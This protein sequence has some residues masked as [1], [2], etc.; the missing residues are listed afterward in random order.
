LTRVGSRS[1]LD[2]LE[3]KVAVTLAAL[4][5]V[6]VKEFDVHSDD[7]S[8]ADPVIVA[9]WMFVIGDGLHP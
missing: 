3:A 9:D 5:G 2:R 8:G 7:A 1:E 4:L 6:G